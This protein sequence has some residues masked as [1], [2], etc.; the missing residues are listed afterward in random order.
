MAQRFFEK[1]A[2][3]SGKKFSGKPLRPIFQIFSGIVRYFSDL[4]KLLTRSRRS[5]EGKKLKLRPAKA[6]ASTGYGF[7]SSLNLL[8]PRVDKESP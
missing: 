7:F 8:P 6:W 3:Y 5:A 4:K 1:P 2:V